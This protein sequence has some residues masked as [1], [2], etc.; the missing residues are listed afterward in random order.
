MHPANEPDE[1]AT[2]QLPRGSVVRW[3]TSRT[4]GLGQIDRIDPDGTVTIR[5]WLPTKSKE[6]STHID[7]VVLLRELTSQL[8]AELDIVQSLEQGMR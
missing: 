1:Q 5:P 7:R 8:I 2:N 4:V 6:V 3:R